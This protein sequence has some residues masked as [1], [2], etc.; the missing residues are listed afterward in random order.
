VPRSVNA[1]PVAITQ[2]PVDT[3]NSNIVTVTETYITAKAA[4]TLVFPQ[5]VTAN[6]AST[7]YRQYIQSGSTTATRAT[8]NNVNTPQ[9]IILTTS[10]SSLTYNISINLEPEA[11]ITPIPIDVDINTNTHSIDIV[12]H[13]STQTTTSVW[14]ALASTAFENILQLTI[15]NRACIQWATDNN[16]ILHVFCL[17]DHTRFASTSSTRV[18]V[19]SITS[20]TPS[21]DG[22][23]IGLIV[24][25]VNGNVTVLDAQRVSAASFPVT[26]TSSRRRSI[27]DPVYTDAQITAAYNTLVTRIRAE[28][29]N[30]DLILM[31]N[32]ITISVPEPDQL[33]FTRV[34][35]ADG[36]AVV[37]FNAR[38]SSSEYKVV[39]ADQATSA[40]VH[41]A[42]DTTLFIFSNVLTLQLGI[43]NVYYAVFDL[44]SSIGA[45][46]VVPIAGAVSSTATYSSLQKASFDMMVADTLCMPQVFVP[47][48]S[49]G[50]LLDS[51]TGSI[52]NT[53]YC[54][55]PD[56]ILYNTA[57]FFPYHVRVYRHSAESS[58]SVIIIVVAVVVAMSSIIAIALSVYAWRRRTFAIAPITKRKLKQGV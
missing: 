35:G 21:L 25:A 5:G 37:M 44:K 39:M 16:E 18:N 36:V 19:G 55:D 23:I 41:I 43:E 49:D 48:I 24:Q 10:D 13:P 1:A 17:V 31:S 42:Q 56:N 28:S 8:F 22:F 58:K 53:P 11:F 12:I 54:A 45:D 38:L 50:P 34:P 27:G 15:A 46:Y 30:D 14:F 52:F 9:P 2:S 33:A 47:D 3:E 6:T 26:A 40:Y 29:P 32:D 20:Q 7:L 4:F 57:I 51:L